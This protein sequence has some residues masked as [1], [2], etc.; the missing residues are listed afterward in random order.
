MSTDSSSQPPKPTP[1]QSTESSAR[2]TES[3]AQSTQ[4]SARSTGALD[5]FFKISE[6]G[7]TLG[8]EFRG[9]LVTFFTMAY[10]VVLNPIIIGG[11]PGEPHNAD[12]LG[13]VLPIAQVAAVTALVAG[14]MS[15]IFGLVANYPFAIATGLGINSLL[16]VTIAPQ[17]TWPEAMGLVVID[18]IIIVL[19]AVTGFRTAVF[20]A[21]PAELKAAIAAGIGAFI[22][23]VGFVDAGF[24][25]RIPDAAGTTVPVQLGSGNSITTIPTLVFVLGVLLM[26]VLV[27]RRVPGGLLIGIA[28]TAVASLIL[29]SVLHLGSGATKPGGW[30]LSVPE[31]PHSL[32][33]L[34]NLSLVGDVDLFGAFTR[35]GVL[36][37]CVLVFALVL[38]NF[39]D[40]MGTMT[41]LGKEAGLTDAKGN[42]PG[43]GRALVVEGTGAIAGGVA[44]SSSNTVFVESASGIAEGARTGLANIVTG[45]LFLAAMFF[46]PVYEVIP[47]EAV[48]PA[49]VIVGGLMIAQVRSID[50][51]NFAIALP[52]FLTIVTMPFTYSIANGIGVGFI[53]WVVMATAAGKARTVHP[54][55]W[56]VAIVFVAYFARQPISDLLG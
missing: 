14:V 18:G 12:V 21:V 13:H 3:G 35:V 39:F 4:E 44:S 8:R 28:V 2:S 36:A 26:G 5:R 22:A 32:G 23:F 45:V 49:L 17:M 37:A 24:V 20:N 19:L 15:I 43:I 56:L 30:G 53:S 25:R 47:S 51:T 10:I 54:L 46:T 27:V 40:A 52:T 16:A 9:G 1:A 31:I 11:I 38:S 48:A 34:P 42:L 29:E 50:F 41:G 6:R 55:M 7:S 33:G